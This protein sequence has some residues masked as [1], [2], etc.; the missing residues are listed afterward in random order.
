MVNKQKVKGTKWEN[1]FI[2][3]IKDN[4]PLTK[5]AKRIAGSGSIGTTLNEPLLKGDILL[6]F[7][8]FPQKF[9]VEAKTGYG[10]NSQLTIRREWLN[11]IIEEAEESY[12]VPALACKFL[13]AK[14][15]GGVQYFIIF[16]IDTFVDIIN[17]VNNL[18]RE[19]D[20]VY[21]EIGSRE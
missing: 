6:D 18:K 4:I 7:Y 2:K 9:R 19:L 8:G 14:S 10:G 5:Q 3:I 1:D 17:Y 20:L 21:E 15:S 16:D 11:K 13:G 12:S